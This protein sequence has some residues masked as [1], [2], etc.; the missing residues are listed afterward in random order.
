MWNKRLYT[1]LFCLLLVINNFAQTENDKSSIIK[2]VKG[3][4]LD[5][6][7]Q[8]PLPYANVVV[9]GKNHGVTTNEKGFFSI[10]E[11]DKTDTLSFHYI[12]YEQKKIAAND[13]QNGSTIY[14]KEEIFSLNEFFV[15]AN[16][17][18]A[19][20]IVKNVL[21]N[22]EKNYKS[23][24][25]KKQ[26]FIRQ[27]YISNVDKID[28]NFKKSSFAHLD[29]KMTKIIEKKIPKQSISYTDFLG[30][31]YTS[32]NKKDTLKL[33]PTKVVSLKDK[34]VADLDQLEKL[35]TKM[36]SNT[37]E[38]EYWKIKSGIIGGKVDV[39]G[40]ESM[41]DLDSLNEFY[42]NN[43]NVH[44]YAKRLHSRF[45]NLLEDKKKWDFL[46]H[47]GNYEYT[48]VGGTKVN[49]EDVF[50]IDFKPKKSGELVGRI[51][52]AIDTYAL[53]KA[54]FKYDVGKTGTDIHLFGVGYTLNQLDISIYFEKK[55]NNY[56]LK[57]YAQKT[58]NKV[59]FDRNVSLLKKKKRFLVDKELNE[60]KVRLNMLSRE[61][62]SFEVLVLKDEKISNQT[63]TNFKEKKAFRFIYVDQFND[64]IWRGYDI[65]E[66]TKQ[67][68][69]YK[70]I[71]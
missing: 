59:S 38:N 11:I 53:V 21:K 66:P 71:E 40:S 10:K 37:K 31:V 24:S 47:T 32:N 5:E 60:I 49:G 69:D 51:Y 62:S 30:D 13:L 2:N 22:K 36:F 70:K 63:Y 54:D 56:Q 12:G 17:H 65:I 28:I 14:L 19:E 4:L 44:F 52:I 18:N 68:R 41:S 27:R 67:M 34:N 15:F 26:L 33:D 48:L 7:T 61:E 9:L 8:A 50:I 42:K 55:E 16:N 20:D 3:V 29:E 45:S 25:T 57:Y 23:T 58:G 46:H 1:S 43:L 35:F 6:N 64:N 39:N